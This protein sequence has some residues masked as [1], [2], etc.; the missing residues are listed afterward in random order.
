[1]YKND[2]LPV[3]VREKV[4]QAVTALVDHDK[5]IL[6]SRCDGNS[7]DNIAMAA[8][9]LVYDAIVDHLFTDE[10][11]ADAKVMKIIRTGLDQ[12][13]QHA[14]QWLASAAREKYPIVKSK[15]GR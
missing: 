12:L 2:K 4:Q 15:K 1:M 14:A 10:A 5:V 6:W 9:P 8:G 3:L 7:L 13:K 11:L